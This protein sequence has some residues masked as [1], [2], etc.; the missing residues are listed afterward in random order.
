MSY[1]HGD[2]QMPPGC[3][4]TYECSKERHHEGE[5]DNWYRN[6]PPSDGC[7][8]GPTGTPGWPGFRTVEEFDAFIAS[9]PEEKDE[10]M[11]LREEWFGGCYGGPAGCPAGES[12]TDRLVLEII[13]SPV[14]DRGYSWTKTHLTDAV[15][16]LREI[17]N[18]EDIEFKEGA[19]CE[20]NR[21]HIQHRRES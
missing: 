11:Y 2:Y 15:Y 8:C 12:E 7:P 20:C 18:V 4:Q 14:W 13:K 19:Q 16:R 9:Y 6:E 3:C 21:C 10:L 1:K 17:Y 5:C